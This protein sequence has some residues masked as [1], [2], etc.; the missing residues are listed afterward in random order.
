MHDIVILKQIGPFSITAYALCLMA[1][2]ALAILMTVWLN[3][4]KLG[5]DAALSMSMCAVAGAFIGARLFYCATMLEFIL[6]DLGG[7]GF[8]VKPWEGGY[9]MYGA[10]VGGLC[11]LAV[12]TRVAKKNLAQVLDSAAPGAALAIALGRLGEY[13][14]SQGLGHYVENEALWRFP[15]AVPSVYEDWQLPV[16]V[17]EAFAALVVMAVCL[18]LMRKARAGRTAEVFLALISLSQILLESLR[19]DEFIRFGFV[20]FN[21]LA[22]ALVLGAVMLLSMR[23]CVKAKGWTV[24]QIGRLVIFTA[25]IVVV[26][27]IEFALDKSPIDN[28]ILYAVMSATLALMGVSILCEGKARA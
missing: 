21:M 11:G 26:I 27:L 25:A 19:A 17:Y 23:R 1:G 3:R 22:A 9:N 24:W 15:F 18:C 28:R 2:A 7:A 10:L 8:L 5:V 14:T 6:V 4:K 20:K 16:F 12:Y 13:C